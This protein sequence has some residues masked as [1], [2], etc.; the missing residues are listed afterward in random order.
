MKTTCLVNNFNYSNFVVEAVNSALNQS[1]NFDEI[2]IVDDASTDQSVQILNEKFFDS[3]KI[4]LIFKEK[5]EGQLS[6][7]NEGYLASSGDIIFFLDADD[8]Y[9]DTYLEEA[10]NFYDKNKECDFLFCPPEIFGNS[11]GIYLPSQSRLVKKLPSKIVENVSEFHDNDRDLGYS[12]ILTLH[13]RQWIGSATSTLSLRREILNNILPIPYVRDWWMDADNCLIYGSSLAGARKFYM[14]KPLV[15]YR[16]HGNNYYIGNSKF[17]ESYVYKK[18]LKLNRLFNFLSD[19]MD[20]RQDLSELA[21]LEFRTIP[22]PVFEEFISYIKIIVLSKMNWPKK[23]A[24]LL[25]IIKYFF[26]K[27]K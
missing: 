12:V 17:N 25:F 23:F 21:H 27:N 13:H 9:K 22:N 20:Y 11:K 24:R 19:K 5:N 6:C 16:F 7:F 14:A 15:K 2:I 8:L 1:V 4:K 3:P 18:N 10:L 26:S